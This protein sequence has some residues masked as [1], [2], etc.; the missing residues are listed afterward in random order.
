MWVSHIKKLNNEISSGVF[1]E[2]SKR[3]QFYCGNNIRN[4]YNI[5]N[6]LTY[7]IFMIKLLEPKISFLKVKDYMNIYNIGPENLSFPRRVPCEWSPPEYLRV[8]PVKLNLHSFK[9]VQPY[10]DDIWNNW[11]GHITFTGIDDFKVTDEKNNWVGPSPIKLRYYL[12]KTILDECAKELISKDLWYKTQLYE[13]LQKLI[14][15]IDS[16]EN[17]NKL[18]NSI[19][20]VIYNDLIDYN[21]YL[22]K[23]IQRIGTN[24]TR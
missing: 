16:S 24:I 6:D 1:D 18:L 19:K 8:H 4:F 23:Y 12:Q 17:F 7:A 21:K 15:K 13:Q 22:K 2:Q 11:N 5:N 9:C 14:S 20:D 3:H 10:S